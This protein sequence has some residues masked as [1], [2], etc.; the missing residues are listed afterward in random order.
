[1]GHFLINEPCGRAQHRQCHPWP[2]PGLY[3]KVNGATY[4]EQASKQNSS[5]TSDL[6]SSSVILPGVPALPFFL[7]RV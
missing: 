4:K 5:V 6:I 2:S 1:M 3:K 7:G